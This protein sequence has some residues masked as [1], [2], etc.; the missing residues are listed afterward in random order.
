MK[1]IKKVYEM[2]PTITKV[3]MLS[4][5]ILP[6]LKCLFYSFI[7]NVDHLH[8]VMQ[9]LFGNCCIQVH[10]QIR[11]RCK[12]YIAGITLWCLPEKQVMRGEVFVCVQ[13]LISC[14]MS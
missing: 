9:P 10:F 13:F 11:C 12:S 6:G 4:T 14:H 1:D 8:S 3:M 5:A 2:W 7:L